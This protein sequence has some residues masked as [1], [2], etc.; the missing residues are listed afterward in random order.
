MAGFGM[1]FVG[2][3]MMSASMKAFAELESVKNFL[4]LIKI[5]FCSCS[6]VRCSPRLFKVRRL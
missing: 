3:D 6:S 4:A 2:L 1:L 5:R